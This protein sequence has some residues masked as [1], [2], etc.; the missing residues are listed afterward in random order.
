MLVN[1]R[2]VEGNEKFTGECLVKFW[3]GLVSA[4]RDALKCLLDV[5]LRTDPTWCA[6][7]GVTETT[8]DEWIDAIT[9]VEDL[10]EVE[11]S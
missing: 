11:P 4:D 6:L 5:A 3:K 9:A 2:F 8:E 7:R 1:R 10:L